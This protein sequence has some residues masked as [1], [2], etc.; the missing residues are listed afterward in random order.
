ME[1]KEARSNR[2][3]YE[4]ALSKQKLLQ[5]N[6][7]CLDTLDVT[8]NRPERLRFPRLSAFRQRQDEQNPFINGRANL[9]TVRHTK[10]EANYNTIPKVNVP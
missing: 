1:W 7:N 2:K 4:N 5:T 3:R 6:Q 10:T 9:K 8:R